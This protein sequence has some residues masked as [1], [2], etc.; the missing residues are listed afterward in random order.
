MDNSIQCI[1]VGKTNR[2]IHWILIYPVD[3]V[4][5]RL[6]EQLGRSD[7][8]HVGTFCRVE[9]CAY[10]T[11]SP[12]LVPFSHYFHSRDLRDQYDLFKNR[13]HAIFERAVRLMLEN[14]WETQTNSGSRACDCDMLICY[15]RSH[16][17]AL[18][19]FAFPSRISMQKKDRLQWL[20]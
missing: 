2:V 17:S 7:L 4:I 9:L 6:F 12:V 20:I 1:S 14:P 13:M 8:G 5:I 15:A 16:T 3:S 19:C 18:T 11:N 10:L